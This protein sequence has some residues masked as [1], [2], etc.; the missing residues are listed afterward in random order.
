MRNNGLAFGYS[1]LGYRSL[2][3]GL[4][5][6]DANPEKINHDLDQHWEVLG[7]PIQTVMR[8]YNLESPYELLKEMTRGKGFVD[9]NDLKKL[10]QDSNLPV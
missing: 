8:K 2:I 7:E 5:K 6:L 9:R 10:I 3:G 1:I 4:E